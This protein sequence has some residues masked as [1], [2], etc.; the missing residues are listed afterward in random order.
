MLLL[1]LGSSNIS[2]LE[3]ESSLGVSSSTVCGAIRRLC[4]ETET[5]ASDRRVDKFSSNN[6]KGNNN[7]NN[8]MRNNNSNE[9]R[10]YKGLHCSRAGG[11][12]GAAV[13]EG[14]ENCRTRSK[15]GSQS[16]AQEADKKSICFYFFGG[17]GVGRLSGVSDKQQQQQ[18]TPPTPRLP[19]LQSAIKVTPE[20]PK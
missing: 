1:L 4:C 10:N 8:N 13:E 9:N 17:R 16:F 6:S 7:N 14:G 5:V 15:S 11:E 2:H 12:A 19:A 18:P 3:W 20:G